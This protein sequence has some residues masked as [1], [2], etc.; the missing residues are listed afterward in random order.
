MNAMWTR[1]ADRQPDLDPADRAPS[2]PE[3]IDVDLAAYVAQ[4]RELSELRAHVA[5]LRSSLAMIEFDLDGT[6]LDANENF[7]AAMGYSLDEIRG[8][9]H[10]MFVD[11]QYARSDEYR[12]FWDILRSGRHHAARYKRSAKGGREIWI[13]ATYNPILDE[14]GRPVKVVKYATDITAQQLEFADLRGRA[15]AIGASLAVIEFDLDGTILTA[16]DN[17]CAA[18]GYRLDEIRGRHHRTFVD[19]ADAA[20]D[21]YRRF[22]EI[23]RSGRFHVGQ[24][25]R[26]AKGG[27]E[28]WIQATYNPILDAE[29]RPFKIVKFATD[30]T[31]QKRM[32]A[33]LKTSIDDNF[34][35]LDAVVGKIAAESSSAASRTAANVAALASASDELAGSVRHIGEIVER[36]KH[37]VDV[38]AEHSA[39]A[40]ATTEE[41]LAATNAMTRCVGL[42]QAIA[43]QINLLAL[44]A[45]IEAARAGEAGKGFAVVA[46]E[47]KNLAGQAASATELITSE[48]NGLQTRAGQVSTSLVSIAEAVAQV[49]ESFASTAGAVEEQAVVSR[50]MSE[51]MN[52]VSVAVSTI[53]AQIDELVTAVRVTATAV[54]ETRDAAARLL[55]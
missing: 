40:A 37:T 22:W 17:F 34:A 44:N 51:G 33:Q 3:R 27:R 10:R 8:R 15:S 11:E 39:S 55:G 18:M 36:S 53:S 43:S 25:R 28:V 20:G 54:D 2:S 23:L 46:T 21:D 7:C 19:P 48:I 29:G 16:N 45:T 31:A 24:Y 5:A 52:S 41:L 47:V 4:Q 1:L 50:N 26:I 13:E 35:E 14:H 6:I 42:I 12:E 49:R 38:T 9:H 30:I 32:M